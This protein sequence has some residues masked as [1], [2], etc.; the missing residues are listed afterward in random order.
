[1]HIMRIPMQFNGGYFHNYYYFNWFFKDADYFRSRNSWYFPFGA[2][3]S[4]AHRITTMY[5]YS[6]KTTP[7]RRWKQYHRLLNKAQSVSLKNIGAIGGEQ[8]RR[9][10]AG[11][12]TYVCTRPTGSEKITHWRRC[13]IWPCVLLRGVHKPKALENELPT[14]ANGCFAPIQYN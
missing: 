6:L 5:F 4:S 7:T 3:T 10:L 1:M 12:R 13:K 8:Q 14:N 11:K 2:K 9:T